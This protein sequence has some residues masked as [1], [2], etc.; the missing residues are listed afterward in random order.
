MV[1]GTPISWNKF[2][3]SFEF[4]QFSNTLI[5]PFPCKL[6]VVSQPVTAWICGSFSI[7]YLP[8]QLSFLRQ[9]IVHCLFLCT[10]CF[11]YACMY[12]KCTS[13]SL[14]TITALVLLYRA[15]KTIRVSA[16]PWLLSNN[17]STYW[18]VTN[19]V[20]TLLAITTG[21]SAAFSCRFV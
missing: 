1:E 7:T 12:T 8:I 19:Q 6:D 5:F 9:W 17:F 14:E 2:I 13:V 15:C 10:T 4:T 18:P 16:S 21:T 3:F 11:F 20:S